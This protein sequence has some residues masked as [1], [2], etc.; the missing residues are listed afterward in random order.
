MTLCTSQE[1][2]DNAGPLLVKHVSGDNA[3]AK[4]SGAKSSDEKSTEKKSSDG[5]DGGYLL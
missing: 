1:T 2:G 5:K 3:T 4:A